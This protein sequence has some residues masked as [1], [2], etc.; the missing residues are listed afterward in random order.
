VSAGVTKLPLVPLLP[1]ERVQLVLFV[2]D[3]LTT[4]VP[5]YAID[6]GFAVSET[7]G[8]GTA[9]TVTT[10]LCAV[11]PPLPVHVSVYVVFVV[12]ETD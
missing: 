4:D 2:D 5:P 9:E 11:L 6:E 10:V 8:T 12:G 7:W 3:Q 1:F